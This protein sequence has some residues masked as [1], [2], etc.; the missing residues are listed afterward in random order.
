MINPFRRRA[1]LEQQQAAALHAN[2]HLADLA[3]ADLRAAAE[4]ERLAQVAARTSRVR[5]Q[6]A[7]ADELAA[8]ADAFDAAI[9]DH[10][11]AE[12]REAGRIAAADKVLGESRTRLTAAVRAADKALGGLHEAAAA[13]DALVASTAAELRAAGL[14]ARVEM[15]GQ[16][17]DFTTGGDTSGAVVL[18]GR[19]WV[20]LSPSWTLAR[21]VYGALRAREGEQEAVGRFGAHDDRHTGGLFDK[22]PLPAPLV[23]EGQ[24]PWAVA[25]E[26]HNA[27]MAQLRPD[28]S[29]LPADVRSRGERRAREMEENQAI[30]RGNAQR[31]AQAKAGQLADVGDVASRS[32]WL[33]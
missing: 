23:E 3:P 10:A 1:E 32:S 15:G 27:L 25:R 4:A 33:D 2:P 29:K 9:T 6:Q 16:V 14:P 19:W 8:Q 18:A 20:R 28:P 13:H 11:E 26:A 12:Q 7:R 31:L 30:W 24:D 21:T 17:V 22:A 5:R